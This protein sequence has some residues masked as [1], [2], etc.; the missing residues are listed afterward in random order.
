MDKIG[1]KITPYDLTD[2][3]SYKAFL[4]ESIDIKTGILIREGFAYGNKT[5]SLSENAQNNL[6]GTVI[7]KDALTYP[8][9]W[10]TKDDSEVYQ[11]ADATEMDT[12]FMSAL[13]TKKAYQDSGTALKVSVQACTTIAELEA[14]V[15]NR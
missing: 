1:R 2:V 4:I 12:F 3:S 13:G 11:I 14:I 7:K 9:D 8:L 6:L 15:D 5:F 10:S